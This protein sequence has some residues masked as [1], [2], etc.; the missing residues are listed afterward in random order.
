MSTMRR[1]LPRLA[2]SVRGRRC[3]VDYEYLNGNVLREADGLALLLHC[4]G[5]S[6][7]QWRPMVESLEHQRCHFN[8]VGVNSFG[9][10][11]SSVPEGLAASDAR[12]SD[13][14]DAIAA[15]AEV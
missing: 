14:V 8:L 5:A 1:A 15:L 4:S 11:H 13:Q 3:E 10:G 2:T 12:M 6:S 7:K 9:A